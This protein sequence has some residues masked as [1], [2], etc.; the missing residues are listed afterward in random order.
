[1]PYL[2]YHT[3]DGKPPTSRFTP[4]ED[5]QEA[6]EYFEACFGLAGFFENC[7]CRDYDVDVDHDSNTITIFNQEGKMV[8]LISL[9]DHPIE[10]FV[11]A[12]LTAEHVYMVVPR[13]MIGWEIRG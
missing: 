7:T 10:E 4:K 11:P 12:I 3:Y 8:K 1:M 2:H 5:V 13:H 6:Q 9:E